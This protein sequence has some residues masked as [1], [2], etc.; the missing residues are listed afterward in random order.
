MAALKAGDVIV[1]LGDAKIAGLEDFD[2]ALRAHRAGD[3]VAVQVKRGG[4]EV[5][6]EV[7]LEPPR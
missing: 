5:Q 4:K 7:R 1:R 3:K 2:G 6:L